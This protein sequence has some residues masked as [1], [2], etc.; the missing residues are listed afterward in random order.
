[1]IFDLFNFVYSKLLNFMIILPISYDILEF[2]NLFFKVS[3]NICHFLWVARFFFIF[4]LALQESHCIWW[5]SLPL[6]NLWGLMASL[7][8]VLYTLLEGQ[9]L[10]DPTRQAHCPYHPFGS[11]LL[12]YLFLLEVFLFLFYSM[13]FQ[14]FK[15]LLFDDNFYTILLFYF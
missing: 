10:Y 3:L 2:L 4:S 12:N 9:P 14:N 1:M 6:P 15:K 13:G 11:F 8:P 7:P 5:H